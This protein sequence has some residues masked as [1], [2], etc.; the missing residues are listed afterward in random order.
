MGTFTIA[1]DQ[2][3]THYDNLGEFPRKELLNRLGSTHADKMYQDKNDGSTVCVGYIIAGLW[4]T[5]YNLTA[6][7]RIQ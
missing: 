3:G 1:I 7:E 6:W 5:I 2:Y 4:L